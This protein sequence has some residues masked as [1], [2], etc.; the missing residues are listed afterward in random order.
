LFRYYATRSGKLRDIGTDAIFFRARLQLTKQ[1]LNSLNNNSKPTGD[2][3]GVRK[4][5]SDTSFHMGLSRG[6]SSV[7][8]VERSDAS[9]LHPKGPFY[10][11]KLSY[12][13]GNCP[14]RY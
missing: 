9:Q 5:Y 14:A 2:K 13:V 8:P 1:Y 11:E 3:L 7:T 12:F 6:F 10:R 4:G